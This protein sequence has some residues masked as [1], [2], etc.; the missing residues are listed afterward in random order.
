MSIGGVKKG[1]LGAITALGLALPASGA[2]AIDIMPGDYNVLPSGTNAFLL[3]GQYSTARNLR[4]D[5]PGVGKVPDSELGVA[6]G[7]ARYLHYSD[8]AGVPVAV[9]AFLPFGGFTQARIGGQGQRK[10]G[11]IGDLTAG[12]TVWPV[13]TT[14]P[15]S[16]TIGVTAYVTAPTGNYSARPG[17]VSIGS[18][19]W[20]VMP[21]IGLIQGLGG[22]F[23]LDV[24]ADV[25]IRDDHRE[26]GQKISRDPSTQFQAYLRYQIS[27]ASSLSFGYSGLFG[28]KDSVGSSYVGT[29]TRSDQLRVF[30]STMLTPTLQIQGM[31]G[32][33][34]YA[35]TGFKQDVV[36]TLRL[37]K[38]F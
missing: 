14:G 1:L 38:L 27:A 35:Q 28:G 16:T 36:G 12:L 3:Y 8:I 19:T 9:Q 20:S 7:I 37:L 29:K 11:G 17:T 18:G 22:S 30:A 10:E 26:L 2:K 6:L 4:V 23:F 21:Q 33:D 5:L 25:N 34:I 13:N 32:T 31:I 15:Y 24:A